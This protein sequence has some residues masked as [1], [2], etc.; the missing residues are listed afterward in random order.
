[1]ITAS[2]LVGPPHRK[3]D[4]LLAI[5]EAINIISRALQLVDETGPIGD[6]AAGGDEGA[7]EGDHGQLMPGRQR[8]NQ[9]AMMCRQRT[10]RNDQAAVHG[11]LEGRD[12]VENVDWT[13][14]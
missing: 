4:R 7:F 5:E 10:P 12:G 13:L 1:L 14:A 6:Q 3:T 9:I 11:A 2:Y 8:D